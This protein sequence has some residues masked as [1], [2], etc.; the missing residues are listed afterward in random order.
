[1]AG[2]VYDTGALVAAERNS[3][4]MWAL[5]AALLAEEIVP[6]VPAP[7]LA[8]AWR[9]GAR[10]ASLARLLALCAVEPMSEEQ[11]RAVGALAGAAQHNDIVDVTVVECAVRSGAGVATADPEHIGAIAEAAGTR[12]RIESV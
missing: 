1:M 10:Q 9:G 6:I 3:R 11:A 5:H 4:R 7:V 2:V 12:L 8:E